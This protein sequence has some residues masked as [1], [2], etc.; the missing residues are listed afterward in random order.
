MSHPTDPPGSFEPNRDYPQIDMGR[1]YPQFDGSPPGGQVPPGGPNW[2]SPPP[3]PPKKN[4]S[5]IAWLGAHKAIAIAAVV[6]IS[7]IAV[8]ASIG[9]RLW[10]N[11]TSSAGDS[12]VAAAPGQLTKQYPTAPTEAWTLT[13]AE[14]RGG[15]TFVSTDPARNQYRTAGILHDDDTVVTLLSGP[16]RRGGPVVGVRVTDG[17]RW[18]TQQSVNGCSDRIVDNVLA[19]LTDSDVLFINTD[20]GRVDATVTYPEGS[21]Y[22][23]GFDGNA[24]FVRYFLWS[25]LKVAKI[26]LDGVIWQQDYSFGD[27]LPS[28]DASEVMT[29]DKYFASAGGGRV[30]V[31]A[32]DD[33][34]EIVNRPGSVPLARLA[35]GGIAFTAG[36]VTGNTVVQ[37]PVVAVQAD[38]TSREVP[39][40]AVAAAAVASRD[41]TGDVIVDGIPRTADSF[42][43]RWS[44]SP[45]PTATAVFVAGPTGVALFDEN[46]SRLVVADASTG[47]QV[48]SA[49]VGQ[50]YGGD[51]VATDGERLIYAASSGSIIAADLASGAQVWIA[52]PRAGLIDAEGVNPTVPQIAAVG[53]HLVVATSVGLSAFAPTG[54]A[55]SAPGAEAAKAQEA[56]G[57]DKYVTKCGT[58]PTFTP[59]QFTTVSGGLAIRMRVTATCPDGDILSGSQTRITV[60]EGSE[61][62][63]SGVFDLSTTPLVIS[64]GGGNDSTAQTMDL[65]FPPG[66]FFRLPDT[67]SAASGSADGSGSSTGQTFIVECERG[68]EASSLAIGPQQSDSGGTATAT[69]PAVSGQAEIDRSVGNALRRQADSDRSFILASLNNHWVAQL[70][71]KRPGLVADGRTWTNQA[72]LDEFL[73]LRLRFADARLLYSDEW[74]VFDYRG[75]WVTVA[76]PTFPGPDAANNWCRAQGFDSDHCFAK[77]LSTSAGSGGS[78]RY[79]R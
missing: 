41:Y 65:V 27:G 24:A 68:P 52:A 8:V 19:C 33:G 13:A 48:W 70:S 34:R 66:S 21:P 77:F 11:D 76:T 62:I 43:P 71:S 56:E 32:T 16:S 12:T 17:K 42:D 2:G 23:V 79:W 35:D 3:R 78:T 46:N 74:P 69:A 7:I 73:A 60:R 54:G 50:V 31:I 5:P 38:G 40:T 36:A 39:G 30:V 57:S 49:E 26:G 4:A 55:A 59:E 51:R 67:L 28:G 10:G 29:T 72:I 1:A 37:G 18:Q 63:A 15:Q 53:D 58:P 75:W 64:G 14:L 25:G 22:A 6:G 44:S 61:L 20:S 47:A 45:V 9:I